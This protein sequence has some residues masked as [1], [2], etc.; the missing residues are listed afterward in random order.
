MNEQQNPVCVGNESGAQAKTR[1]LRR[2]IRN[3][4]LLVILG[5]VSLAAG[6]ETARTTLPAPKW[7]IVTPAQRYSHAFSPVRM[8]TPEE[9]ELDAELK[10][11]PPQQQA[12]RLLEQNALCD[13]AVAETVKACGIE[14]THYGRL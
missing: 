13:P 4:A 12:E 11:L 14:L 9:N 1:L 5:G 10:R 6:F 7:D 8:P 2:G 3:V